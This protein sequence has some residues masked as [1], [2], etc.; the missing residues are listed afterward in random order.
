MRVPDSGFIRAI[1]R[2]HR[3]ALALTSANVSQALSSVQ[4]SEFTVSSTL[5]IMSAGEERS[6]GALPGQ[7]SLRR[8]QELGTVICAAHHEQQYSF[9]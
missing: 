9:L 2:Q 7:G 3:G 5:F 6:A 1:C 4:V 8:Q